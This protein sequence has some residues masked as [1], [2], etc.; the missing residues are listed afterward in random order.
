[1]QPGDPNMTVADRRLQA[2]NSVR[3]TLVPP[4]EDTSSREP[5]RRP[6]DTPSQGMAMGRTHGRPATVTHTRF[7]TIINQHHAPAAQYGCPGIS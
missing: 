3:Q 7:F 2:T 5:T 1:M 4:L 6:Q